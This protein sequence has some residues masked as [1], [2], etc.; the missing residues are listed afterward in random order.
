L[1]KHRAEIPKLNVYREAVA[2]I[3]LLGIQVISVTLPMVEAATTASARHE[4]LTGDALII[5]VM[6][7]NGLT[8]LASSD[9]DFDRV[10][11]ITRYTPV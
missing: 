10:P 7:A 5:A 2:R 8:N 4:L 3:G 9:S 6:N 1:R 11:G